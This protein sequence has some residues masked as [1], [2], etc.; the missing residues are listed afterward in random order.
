VAVGTEPRKRGVKKMWMASTP[1]LL[2]ITKAGTD[3]RARG[4]ANA[5]SRR[6]WVGRHGGT[7]GTEASAALQPCLTAWWHRPGVPSS[8]CGDR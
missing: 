7:P 1:A 4:T 8:L 2:A 5:T 3:F 6:D